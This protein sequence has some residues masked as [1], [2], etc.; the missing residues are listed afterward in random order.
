M[1]H[2]KLK[3][4]IVS[5][6]F[7]MTMLSI[8]LAD[9][10]CSSQDCNITTSLSV[11]ND[12]PTAPAIIVPLDGQQVYTSVDFKWTASTDGNGDAITYYLAYGSSENST[13]IIYSGSS[14]QYLSYSPSSSGTYYWRVRASDGTVN[15]SWSSEYSFKFGSGGTSGGGSSSTSSQMSFAAPEEEKPT[16]IYA[17]LYAF[18]TTISPEYPNPMQITVIVFIIGGMG[19]YL[20]YQDSIK[21]KEKKE[22]E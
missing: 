1:N 9:T 15:S 11:A 3:I 20:I 21:K 13:T 2:T 6:L 18:G 8:S 4:G 14:T 19:A 22:D 10:E 7:L 5:I 16:G 12:I 17:P